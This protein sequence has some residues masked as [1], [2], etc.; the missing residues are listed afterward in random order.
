MRQLSGLQ[1][2][3]TSFSCSLSSLRFQGHFRI[4]TE[5]VCTWTVGKG[6]TSSCSLSISIKYSGLRI[7]TRV[8]T[9][10]ATCKKTCH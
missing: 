3:Q 7:S 9:A 6:A 8:E 2:L 1:G 10:C 4:S 5:R